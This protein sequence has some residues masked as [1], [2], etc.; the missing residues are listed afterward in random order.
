MPTIKIDFSCYCA[1]CGAGMCYDVTVDDDKIY[2]EP[3]SIC[4]EAARREGYNEGYE[5]AISE[6]AD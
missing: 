1:Q 5:D 4:L 2:I 6:K 3:C